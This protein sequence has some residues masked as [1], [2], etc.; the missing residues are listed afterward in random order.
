MAGHHLL[1]KTQEKSSIVALDGKNYTVRLTYH[2]IPGISGKAVGI[3]FTND[4]GSMDSAEVGNASGLVLARAIGNRVV[5]MITPDL[6]N[7]SIIG[8]YLLTEELGKRKANAIRVKNRAYGH[9]AREIHKRV[10]HKLPHFAS[11]H[12]N[13]GIGWVMSESNLLGSEQYRIFEQE[14]AKPLEALEC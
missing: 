10:K 1:Q 12:T 3:K 8:F 7:I 9:G 13:G 2:E 14:L 6:P 5:Q 4:Q 11:L